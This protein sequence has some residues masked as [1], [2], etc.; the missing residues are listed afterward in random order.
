MMNDPD[1]LT[2]LNETGLIVQGEATL[3]PER[4]ARLSLLLERNR[5]QTLTAAEED[6]LDRF[7]QRIDYLNILKARALL[8]LKHREFMARIGVPLS[9]EPTNDETANKD[10]IARAIAEID[11]ER[12]AQVRN[13]TSAQRVQEMAS[14]IEEAEQAAVK[15]LRQEWP[16]LSEIDALRIYRSRDSDD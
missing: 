16:E 5:Q 15:R 7:L 4:Q 12:L 1:L 13:L 8:T 6:E 14:M 10:R 9:N 3:S 11:L 2:E